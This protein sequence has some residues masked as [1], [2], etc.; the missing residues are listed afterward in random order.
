MQCDSSSFCCAVCDRLQRDAGRHVRKSRGTLTEQSHC[1]TYR[2]LSCCEVGGSHCLLCLL[3]LWRWPLWQE[4]GRPCVFL[5]FGVSAAAR[6]LL[7]EQ[8]GYNVADFRIPDERGHVATNEVIHE[9]EAA[10][11]TTTVRL[12]ELLAVLQSVDP[13]VALS[14]DPGRYVCNY[15]YYRSLVWA[16]RQASKKNHSNVRTCSYVYCIYVCVFCTTKAF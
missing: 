1:G 13:R 10:D 3:L 7:L 2:L 8:V 12:D 11:L 15:V 9:G 5:H 6:T 14:T 4:R 16:T